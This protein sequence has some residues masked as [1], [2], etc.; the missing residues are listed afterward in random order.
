MR[1]E[2]KE[3]PTPGETA[4]EQSAPQATPAGKEK[5]FWLTYTGPMGT[6][7]EDPNTFRVWKPDEELEVT[8]E[9]GDRLSRAHPRETALRS[10]SKDAA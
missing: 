4:P 10:A 3:D 6:T 8:E 1:T 5:H 9:E 7:L 2:P